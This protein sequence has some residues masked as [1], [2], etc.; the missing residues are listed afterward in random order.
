MQKIVVSLFIGVAVLTGCIGVSDR[1]STAMSTSADG[2]V[3]EVWVMGKGESVDCEVI[4]PES[5]KRTEFVISGIDTTMITKDEQQYWRVAIPER[6]RTILEEQIS[7]H[8]RFAATIERGVDPAMISDS[9]R[10]PSIPFAR[11]LR[12]PERLEHK[13]S[14]PNQALQTTPMTR[15]EI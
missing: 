10:I 5:L 13:E 4:S 1:S 11:L 9:V 12:K 3:L 8:Q 7:A 14:Q 15:S 2:L 6:Y